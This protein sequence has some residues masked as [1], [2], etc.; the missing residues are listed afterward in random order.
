MPSNTSYL[1][2]IFYC[3]FLTVIYIQSLSL[4]GKINWDMIIITEMKLEILLSSDRALFKRFNLIYTY[5]FFLETAMSHLP[6]LFFCSSRH[7]SLIR[8]MFC[9]FLTASLIHKFCK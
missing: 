5:I 4:M 6:V 9:N 3:L 2:V 7:L 1:N 8:L